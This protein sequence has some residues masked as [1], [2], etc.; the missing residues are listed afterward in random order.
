MTVSVGH[1]Q[2]TLRQKEFFMYV[3]N[4]TVLYN[5]QYQLLTLKYY[6]TQN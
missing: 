6:T 4:T 3:A 1:C 2:H 5:V